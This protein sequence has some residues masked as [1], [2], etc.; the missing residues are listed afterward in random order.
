MIK[1]LIADDHAVVRKGLITLL[2]DETDLTIV[3]E[4]VDGQDAVEK[5]AQIGPDIVLL[6]LTMPRMSGLEAARVISAKHPGVRALVFS[7]HNSQEYI[8][9]AVE[10]GA[11]GYL[12][13]DTTREEILLAI[14]TV[15][16]GEKYFP[17][18]ISAAIAEALLHKNGTRKASKPES[19]LGKLSRKERQ[20]LNF[21][22]EG[23]SSRE[24]A[25]RLGLSIRTVSNHRANM[26]RKAKVKNTVELVRLALEEKK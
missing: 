6:D 4:A 24:I 8:V 16:K 25:D 18:S 13:K 21:I 5:V 23:L 22:A 14:H 7:M 1:L 19:G 9:N 26:L 20:V 3:G 10:A 2:E 17:P 15:A 12:L 11:W